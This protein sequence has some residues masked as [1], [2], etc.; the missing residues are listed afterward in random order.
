MYSSNS[1]TQTPAE[2]AAT[3]YADRNEPISY[4]HALILQLP[5]P[6]QDT[7]WNINVFLIQH[8]DK[9]L[10]I[11]LA[12]GVGIYMF[13]AVPLTTVMGVAAL[14]IF[15]VNMLS[16][17]VGNL[18]DDDKAWIGV[19]AMVS[20]LALNWPL[21]LSASLTLFCPTLGPKGGFSPSEAF[22]EKYQSEKQKRKNI[23]VA[24]HEK[25]RTYIR[26]DDHEPKTLDELQN[27][28]EEFKGKLEKNSTLSDYNE[29]TIA[30]E[31]YVRNAA[32]SECSR[33]PREVCDFLKEM[34]PFW[35]R[36]KHIDYYNNAPALLRECIVEDNRVIMTHSTE[37]FRKK[38]LVTYSN[39]SDESNKLTREFIQT[40]N[41][42]EPTPCPS[43]YK[44]EKRNK[45]IIH[46]D[47]TDRVLQCRTN[48]FSEI[49]GEFKL[50]PGKKR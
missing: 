39:S 42:R 3:Y 23:R 44:R 10:H 26:Y 27:I 41:L 43:Y 38:S 34:I 35:Y 46:N 24:L 50:E 8:S 29:F 14:G 30:L 2:A 15:A 20:S 18:D 32:D 36:I 22:L 28:L 47:T 45:F 31:A 7:V 25:M 9:V 19:A 1:V 11:G 40:E 37:I 13:S 48:Y 21:S 5:K 4:S 6:M 33:T 12:T 16:S 49:K 17:F